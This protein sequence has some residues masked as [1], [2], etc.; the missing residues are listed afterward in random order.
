MPKVLKVTLSNLI[1]FEK[2]QLPQALANRL[3][4]LA[5]FQNPA[6]Y[7][8]QAMRMSV[9]DKPRV[10]A[11]AE[12]FPSHIALPRGCLEA[13]QD[14]L[15]ANDIRCDLTDERF[16]G[17][18]LDVTFAGILRTD[19]EAA[20]VAMLRHDAGVLCAP[21]AFGKTVTAAASPD[22]RARSTSQ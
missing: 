9:W 2:A 3:I 14:L 8:A 4:R 12:N 17:A 21:T 7:K 18:A 19:Q 1:Y 5:A 13:A 11:C 22:R 10:I 20:V 15:K 16:A 6:F